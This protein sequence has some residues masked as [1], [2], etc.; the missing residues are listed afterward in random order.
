MKRATKAERDHMNDVA[1]LM[2]LIC[3]RPA[4]IHHVRHGGKRNH[5]KC[6]PLC[7]DHHRGGGY[8][9]AIHDGL[10]TWERNFGTEQEMLAKVE[11]MS[12]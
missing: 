10:E 5:S 3:G 8:G 11:E 12:K 2:C 9:V 1:G 4:E 6:F 7:F